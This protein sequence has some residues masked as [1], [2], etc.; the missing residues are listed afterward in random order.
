[1]QPL[2]YHAHRQALHR[3]ALFRVGVAVRQVVEG[4]GQVGRDVDDIGGVE[5]LRREYRLVVRV[6]YSARVRGRTRTA[7]PR[8]VRSLSDIP[9]KQRRI[10]VC[11]FI[12]SSRR[13]LFGRSRSRGNGTPGLADEVLGRVRIGRSGGKYLLY[14]E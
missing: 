8:N 6:E 11:I 10:R 13:I 7:S 9:R 2:Q 14:C 5:W 3:S 12:D 1:M 4:S